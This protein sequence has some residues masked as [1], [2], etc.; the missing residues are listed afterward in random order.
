MAM[1]VAVQAAAACPPVSRPCLCQ[2]LGA[3][4]SSASQPG[5][6]K[7]RVAIG[8]LA[9]T[10]YCLRRSKRCARRVLQPFAIEPIN[11]FMSEMQA[12]IK[13]L[14]GQGLELSA[15]LESSG[16]DP[17]EENRQKWREFCYGFE[18]LGEYCSAVLMEEEALK[19]AT[20]DGRSLPQVLSDG[21]V[22]SAM[23]VDQGFVPLNSFGEKGTEGMVLLDERCQDFYQSGVRLAKWRTQI[24]CNLEMPT[25]VSVWENTDCLARAAR[26]C[27][28]N[29]LAFIAEIQTSQNTGSHSIERTA[30]VCEKAG[31]CIDE[32]CDETQPA[33]KIQVPSLLHSRRFLA[34][35]APG[36]LAPP[37]SAEEMRQYIDEYDRK[38]AEEEARESGAW[39][40]FN[41]N[42]GAWFGAVISGGILYVFYCV[43]D[44]SSTLSDVWAYFLRRLSEESQRHVML[45]AA[46]WRILPKD[47]DK[48]DPYL[49]TEPL[50]GLRFFTPVG[51]APG[52]DPLGEGIPAFFDLGFGFVEVGPV[53]PG[54]K[55]SDVLAHQISTRDSSK[56]IAHFGL[57]GV[58]IGGTKQEILHQL[59]ILGPHVEYLAVDAARVDS[60]VSEVLKLLREMIART[61]TMPGAPRIFLRLPA[62]WP[63]SGSHEAQRMAVGTIAEELR[64]IE[65]AGLIICHDDEAAEDYGGT[66]ETRRLH[67]ELVSEAFR[68]TKGDVVI[69]ASGGMRHGRDA[70]DAVEA[71]ANAVQISSML[72]TEGPRACRRIKDDLAQLLMQEGHKNLASVIGAAVHR[73]TGRIKPKKKRNLWKPKT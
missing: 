69:I 36:P 46:R 42:I 19:F 71:G 63:A 38:V 29:G 68:Q 6:P 18:N 55:D 22:M 34:A 65:A 50:E 33:E 24:E 26:I 31:G 27:Q 56:Q 14:T 17:S 21:G 58:C 72:L 70:L 62:G 11:P 66:E 30:Y 3:S 53:V 35:P 60:D 32:D 9:A 1:L 52:L 2:G 7:A 15:C 59:K 64:R 28:A 73:Q 10:A 44:V 5:R 67:R 23:R 45:Q 8:V 48:D 37:R 13:A 20:N 47:M 16:M 41:S 49:M 39:R 51:L 61:L 54:S 40:R 25:D 43:D 57:L 12:N 4:P